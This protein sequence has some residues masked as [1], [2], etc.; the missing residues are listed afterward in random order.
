MMK[1]FKY[2][3][4]PTH[5]Q[6]GTLQWTLDRCRELY[7]AALQERKEAWSMSK[8]R[9]SAFD[10]M[11]ALTEI[12]AEIR[13]EYQ[14]IGSHV[15]Q[16]VIKRVDKAYKDYFSRLKKGQTPGYP[17]FQGK[18]RYDSFT[19][20]DEWG[21]KLLP[22]EKGKGKIA[23]SKIGHI[24]IKLHRPV[25]GE[26]KTCTI[27]R[28][29]DQWYA[30]FACEVGVQKKLPYTEL[31]IGLDLGLLHFATDSFGQTIEN[32]RYF[33]KSEQKLEHLQ[34]ALSRKKKRNAKTGCKGNRRHKAAKRVRKAHRKIRNQRNDFLHKESRVLVDTFETIVFEDLVPSNMSKRPKPKQD[35][36]GKYLPNGAGVK[37]GLNKSIQ[38]AGWA[39]FV[40][41]CE[42]KA[43]YA[44]T[45]VLKV[46]P[47]NTSQMCSGCGKKGPHKDLSVRTHTCIYCGLVLDR[48]HNAAIN[49]LNRG[50]EVL[51][52]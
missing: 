51:A 12:K 29:G 38:D 31:A 33:R 22:G 34:Q 10:Q 15:L 23:L 27:Y 37:A 49:I 41:F 46:D 1:A 26:I 36:K 32:P 4:Y 42:Y 9:V 25:Q 7:N 13:P 45:T 39:T 52:A 40:A 6:A 35:E 20:P 43:A 21:W 16:D 28:D 44:G 24:K 3:I 11:R 30:V 8:V 48:D 14:E 18:D 2:R 19:F 47:N 5:K 50:L 17:R